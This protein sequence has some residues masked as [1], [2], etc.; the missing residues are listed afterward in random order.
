M[1]LEEQAELEQ[2]V[3]PVLLVEPGTQDLQDLVIPG[4]LVLQDILEL[5]VLPGLQVTLEEL[6]ILDLQVLLEEP[7]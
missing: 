1:I 4:E 6:D 5:L 3:E 7:D 2:L